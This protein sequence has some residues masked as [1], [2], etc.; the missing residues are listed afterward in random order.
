MRRFITRHS[1]VSEDAT[2]DGGHLF[3]EGETLISEMGS[4][5]ARLFGIRMRELGFKGV[6][7]SSPYI[8]TMLT[9]E[10]IANEVDA[11]I[12]PFAPIHEIFRRESQIE[13]YKGYTIEELKKTFTRVPADATLAYPWWVST[14]ETMDDVVE[15]VARGVKLAEELYGDGDI[16]YVAHGA[17]CEALI[18]AYKIPR[19][20]Y[21][22]VFNCSLS[23]VDDTVKKYKR[24]YCD[25]AHLPYAMTTSNFCPKSDIDDQKMN[26]EYE[27]EIDLPLWL[28]K[29]EGEKV[30]HIGDT[31]SQN[32]PFYRALINALKPDVI[33]HTGDMADE[34]KAGRIPLMR[35]EYLH[36]IEVMAKMLRESGAKRIII[37]P[38]NNDLTD[39]I[40]ALLPEA[41][42]YPENSV[43]EIDGRPCRLS[44]SVKALTPD[45]KWCFYG[46]GFTGETWEY[47]MNTEGGECRFNVCN[48]VT[49]ASPSSGKFALIKV[50]ST[51]LD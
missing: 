30:L 23:F 29:V 44:H 6:I 21:D 22:I 49:V 32:Y 36:K 19:K 10:I 37:V 28:S 42:I 20:R 11:K 40:K 51:L 18:R 17:S 4:E 38:G 1:Q 50:P 34:V 3:P 39:E 14:P 41:E 26:A 43:T 48:G 33:I 9:A 15:R 24:G 35:D 2:Y 47:S 45:G 27:G 7:L 25:T 31:E 5:Q 46:H 12:I 16:L 13:K 8:R